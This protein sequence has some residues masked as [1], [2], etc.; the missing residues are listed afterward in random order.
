MRR[1][2]R[3]TRLSILQY[4]TLVAGVASGTKV[5]I[6]SEQIEIERVGFEVFTRGSRKIKL[7]LGKFMKLRDHVCLLSCSCDSSLMPH[8]YIGNVRSLPTLNRKPPRTHKG[9]SLGA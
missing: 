2:S 5:L 1:Y 3:D 9:V 8:D 4:L 6:F 7:Q